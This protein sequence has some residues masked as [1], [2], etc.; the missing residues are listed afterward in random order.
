M[1]LVKPCD[2]P[3]LAV[4]VDT[5]FYG[6]QELRL[7]PPHPIFPRIDVIWISPGVF[8]VQTGI[9]DPSPLEPILPGQSVR[10]IARITINPSSM[11]IVDSNIEEVN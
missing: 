11:M 7:A 4:V 2:P 1:R 8:G 3:S 6:V 9:P 10:K 5:L